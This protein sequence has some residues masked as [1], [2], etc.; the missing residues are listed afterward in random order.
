MEIAH[1]LPRDAVIIASEIQQVLLGIGK[2]MVVKEIKSK[3]AYRYAHRV[4]ESK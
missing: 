2:I 1:G 4:I 3:A